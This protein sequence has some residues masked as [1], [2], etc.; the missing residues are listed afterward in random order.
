MIDATRSLERRASEQL[1]W[2]HRM[3]VAS[4][5]AGGDATEPDG[6][7][8]DRPVEETALRPFERGKGS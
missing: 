4:E 3:V 6:R 5:V 2:V 1:E 7:I 8:V